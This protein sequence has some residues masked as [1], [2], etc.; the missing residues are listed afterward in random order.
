MAQ[1]TVLP[2]CTPSLC[3]EQDEAA[4]PSQAF[5]FSLQQKTF[6]LA[7]M[8]LPHGQSQAKLGR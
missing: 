2:S 8:E 3:S 7:L 6:A 1:S 4:F 5:G